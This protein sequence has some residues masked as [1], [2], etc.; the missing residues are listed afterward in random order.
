[1]ADTEADLLMTVRERREQG[2]GL[3]LAFTL[4]SSNPELGLRNKEFGMS[5]VLIEPSD[6]F[7]EL[8]NDLKP[9]HAR[10]AMQPLISKRPAAKGIGLSRRIIPK[11]LARKLWSIHR[12]IRS[13]QIFSEVPWI[14][15]ELLKLEG[16]GGRHSTQ[17]PFWAEAWELA[18]WPAGRSAVLGI[19]MQRLALTAPGGIKGFIGS[20]EEASFVR[21]LGEGWPPVEVVDVELPKIPAALAS[22]TFD[23]W[24]FIGHGSRSGRDPDG[25][26]LRLEGQLELRPMDLC[27]EAGGFGDA[28]PLVFL[29]ACGAGSSDLSLTGIGGWVQQI[30][31]AGG[32]AFIAPRW[33]VSDKAA[34]MFTETF[35]QQ[36][37]QGVPIGRA[38]LR[39]RQRLK[40]KRPNDSAWLAYTLYG[41]PLASYRERREPESRPP[42]ID[43]ILTKPS[44]GVLEG[45]WRFKPSSTLARAIA[46]L[47]ILGLLAWLLAWGIRGGGAVQPADE[48]TRPSAAG[49]SSGEKP[50][51]SSGTSNTTTSDSLPV[52][53]GSV[54]AAS[55]SESGKKDEEIEH[56]SVLQETEVRFDVVTGKIV[57]SGPP[58]PE[59]GR[60]DENGSN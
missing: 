19:P 13:V 27:A 5:R 45:G 56:S 26:S 34:R 25:W 17:G 16:P 38:V 31:E 39:A 18:H 37:L 53:Q 51:D 43:P 40:T 2:Q 32:G 57:S 47:L 42:V 9:V 48:P 8:W 35:Y 23:G 24:H 6:Y 10:G 14:P 4:Y 21:S 28:T 22:G 30:I 55:G 54:G 20:S 41:H 29:N 15:W 33:A 52:E 46:V 49:D 60:A 59:Q 11:D 3:C 1:M 12:Q 36:F 44:D 58:E 7:R 50:L